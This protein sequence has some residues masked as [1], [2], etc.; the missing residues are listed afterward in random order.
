M[1]DLPGQVGVSFGGTG[2]KGGNALVGIVLAPSVLFLNHT[3]VVADVNGDDALC[4]TDGAHWYARSTS[5]HG[6][7]SG[8]ED[9]LL[10]PTTW[11]VSHPYNSTWDQAAWLQNNSNLGNALEGGLYSGY[12]PYNGSWTNGL[13][14]Y[15]TINNG[16]AGANNG[17]FLPTNKNLGLGV[18][19]GANGVF[20]YNNTDNA[21]IVWFNSNYAVSTPAV[22]MSQGEVTQT[23]G[24]WMGNG[25]GYPNEAFWLASG[26]SSWQ[27][28]GQNTPCANSPYWDNKATNYSWTAGGY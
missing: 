15:Y 7:V 5:G 23:S 8:T 17:T 20:V 1:A 13:L 11:S 22:N 24:T 25:S 3:G 26:S 9:T 2:V 18:Q 27:L 19:S 12:F 6:S 14:G 10:S 4:N 28:W 21:L 16:G